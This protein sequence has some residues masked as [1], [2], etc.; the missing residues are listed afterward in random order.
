MQELKINIF[1][2]FHNCYGII[3]D[4]YLCATTS[5]HGMCKRVFL[6]IQ[7]HMQALF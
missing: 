4:N 7:N 2:K 3:I 6:R 5:A 1:V